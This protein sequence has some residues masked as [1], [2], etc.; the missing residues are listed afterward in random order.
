[1]SPKIVAVVSTRAL[2][3]SQ[4][5]LTAP[6]LPS[7]GMRCDRSPR[8]A[9]A[10]TACACSTDW[11]SIWVMFTSAVTSEAILTTLVTR[12]ISSRIGA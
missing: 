9:A 12:P 2:T 1:M 11:L 8:I 4:S 10:V 6:L 5:T 3:P 7:S